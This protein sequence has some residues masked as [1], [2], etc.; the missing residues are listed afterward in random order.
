MDGENLVINI[1][2]LSYRVDGQLILDG[3]NIEFLPGEIFVIMGPSGCGKSTL[4]RLIMGLIKPTFGWVEIEGQ[5][6]S[7]LLKKEWKKLRTKMGMVFQSAA[8][9]DS[10][11]IFENVAFGLRRKGLPESDI[12]TQVLQTLSIVGLEPS[13]AEKM[14]ADL[15][16]GMKKRAA[17]ARAIAFKPPI[18]LYDEPT[19]GLDPIMANT[20]NELI[21][22]LKKTLGITSL[23]V[24]HD[25]TSA[26]KVADR[27]GLLHQGKLV[28]VQ[29]RCN[30]HNANHP[31][32]QQFLS[33]FDLSCNI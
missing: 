10:L 7:L 12:K 21:L 22:E 23:V 28:E 9:F 11:S 31:V 20:I 30:L 4:L 25:I 3:V 29:E 8:L 13:V 6:T 16:G 2:N 18:L 26:L 14:P 15:S 5:N 27:V 19:T 32:L 33:G 17:I 1:Y 24:T